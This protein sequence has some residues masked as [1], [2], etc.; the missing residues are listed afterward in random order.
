MDIGAEEQR[1]TSRHK[2]GRPRKVNKKDQLM[3]FKC[4]MSER[5]IIEEK[6]AGIYRTT[7][8]FIREIAVTGKID[9]RKLP[10]SP[11]ILQLKSLL[12][13]VAANLNQLTKKHNSAGL[14][15][16][17]RASLKLQCE[18]I[19]SVVLAIKNGLL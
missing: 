10:G 16:F 14:N 17:D 8:E 11:E 9:S 1:N 5:K 15:A 19:K 12:N 13:H 6:A 3:A 7:S 4:T 18:E 2:D